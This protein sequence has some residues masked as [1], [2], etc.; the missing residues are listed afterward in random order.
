MLLQNQRNLPLVLKIYR[1]QSF[2]RHSVVA[3]IN[4]SDLHLGYVGAQ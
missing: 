3:Y 2:V 4:N 1:L